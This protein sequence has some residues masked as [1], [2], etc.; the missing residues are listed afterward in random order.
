MNEEDSQ[1]RGQEFVDW[2]Y[3]IQKLH[4]ELP[5]IMLQLGMIALHLDKEKPETILGAQE[6]IRNL[7]QKL[8]KFK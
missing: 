5:E 8:D 7:L 2:M 3:K 1:S 4:R 6:G